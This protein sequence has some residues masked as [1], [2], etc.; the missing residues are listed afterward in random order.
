M[1]GVVDR[2]P[3]AGRAGGDMMGGGSVANRGVVSPESSG[4]NT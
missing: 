1:V 2:G 3:M 4:G